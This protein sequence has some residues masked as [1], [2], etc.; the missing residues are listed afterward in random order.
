[1]MRA[2]TLHCIVPKLVMEGTGAVSG[3]TY[4]VIDV[5]KGAA[6]KGS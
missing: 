1:M 4:L 6:S 5:T 3:E 2:R